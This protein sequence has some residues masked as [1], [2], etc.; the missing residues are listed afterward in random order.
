MG[1]YRNRHPSRF[2]SVGLSLVELLIAMAIMAVLLSAAVAT[3][4]SG[5]NQ[6]A[7]REGA[8]RIA[9]DLGFAQADAIARHVVRIV[10]FDAAVERY[11]VYS[12]GGLLRDPVSGRLYEVDLPAL[13]PGTGVD[14]A[15]PAFGGS[16]SVRFDAEGTPLSGGEVKLYAGG[17]GWKVC[18]S[19]VTGRITIEMSPP[20][21]TPT[22]P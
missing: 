4:T 18:V 7:A 11:G 2:P 1:R 21:T 16:P 14:L 22:A 5:R 10:T 20:P 6:T 9:A 3:L 12:E 19:N 13:F 15:E 17:E 8:Q